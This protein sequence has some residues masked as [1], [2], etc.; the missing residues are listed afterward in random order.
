[1]GTVTYLSLRNNSGQWETIAGVAGVGAPRRICASVSCTSCAPQSANI[2]PYVG[3]TLVKDGN[4]GKPA[5]SPGSGRVHS[6]KQ[7][8]DDKD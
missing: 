8:N 7:C 4:T 3:D 5:F 2:S 6:K 1:M